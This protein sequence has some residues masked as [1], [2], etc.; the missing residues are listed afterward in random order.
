M[1][2]LLK[3]V[4]HNVTASLTVAR[5]LARQNNRSSVALAAMLATGLPHRSKAYVRCKRK[6]SL[7]SSVLPGLVRWAHGTLVCINTRTRTRRYGR[8]Q[9]RARFG[10]GSRIIGLYV[11]SSG[12]R[13]VCGPPAA[14]ARPVFT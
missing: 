11:R 10:C 8:L 3:L 9:G 2:G 7:L 12:S 5:A 14:A 1:G 13:A 4:G 6:L